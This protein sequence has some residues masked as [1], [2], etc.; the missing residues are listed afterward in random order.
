MIDEPD[1]YRDHMLARHIVSLHRMKEKAIEVDFT[2]EQLQR[3]IRYSRCIKPQMTPEAQRE[4]VDAYVKLRRGDAQPGST[5]S[6]RITVRQLEALVRLSEALARLYCRAKILPKHVREARRLLSESIIAVE[7]R[8]VTLEEDD[9]EIDEDADKGPIL[10]STMR[11]S[12][13]KE[14]RKMENEREEVRRRSDAG[15]P[16]ETN[17]ERE[18]REEREELAWERRTDDTDAGVSGGGGV[19]EDD[20]GMVRDN[21]AA[22]SSQQPAGVVASTQIIAQENIPPTAGKKPK[23]KITISSEEYQ[24]VKN[25]IVNHIIAKEHENPDQDTLGVKQR[26]IVEWY[27]NNEDTATEM[28]ELM[29]ELKVFKMIINKMIN[30]NTLI[31]IQEAPEPA[32]EGDVPMLPDAGE[33]DVDAEDTALALQAAEEQKK[34]PKKKKPDLMERILGLNPNF[35][36]E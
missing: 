35:A 31:V 18:E 28:E 24:S 1:D 3:Y 23:K 13:A 22:P 34:K 19:G 30:E 36:H 7:A 29:R 32:D 12:I 9:D 5:T 33:G 27:A 17:R 15:Q 26:D 14:E 4:I 8:D 25:M 20:D 11:A 6:Y 10:P 21:N 16:A 2:L